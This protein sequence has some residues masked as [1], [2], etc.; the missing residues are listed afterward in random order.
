MHTHI[1]MY[2]YI[3]TYMYIYLY[4][5][6]YIYIYIE[7]ERERDPNGGFLCGGFLVRHFHHC[8]MNIEAELLLSPTP[9][10]GL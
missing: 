7:R 1:H 4:V 6:I 5:C 2:L 3:Y 8:S 10:S 9:R